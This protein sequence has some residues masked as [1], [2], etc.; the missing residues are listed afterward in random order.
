MLKN[1]GDNTV[2]TPLQGL[3]PSFQR[4]RRVSFNDSI[5]T[6]ALM[7]EDLPKSV[8]GVLDDEQMNPKRLDDST[9]VNES[10]D[11]SVR[12]EEEEPRL[13][14]FKF[15][16]R[17]S[18]GS[19]NQNRQEIENNEVEI[20]AVG[21]INETVCTEDLPSGMP[22]VPPSE[23]K[24]LSNTHCVCLSHDPLCSQSTMADR[25]PAS[26]QYQRATRPINNSSSGSSFLRKLH[27]HVPNSTQLIGL[28][29]LVISGAILLLLT[30]ITITATVLALIFFTPL[31]VISSPIWVPA[32]IILFFA[33]ACFLSMCGS[34][35]A[36]VAALS[37]MY[38]YF[39]GFHPPG[40]D[41]FDYARSRIADTA[42]HVKD[43]A[44][45]Y[46]GYLHSKVKDAAPGA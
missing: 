12:L 33:L 23:R 22:N 27:E 34:G 19:S 9:I 46:G 4:K 39:R 35:V 29:T 15:N 7:F 11:S 45:E 25:Q 21:K 42:S 37:W 2:I 3:T 20:Q 24:P 32:G 40:S 30:G 16:D 1:K 13:S 38:R 28:F 44:R 43:Y 18:D 14:S 31:V 36:V 10:D 17:E 8:E 26:G 6:V 5:Q 41:R